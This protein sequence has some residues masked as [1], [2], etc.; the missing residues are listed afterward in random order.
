MLPDSPRCQI[1]GKIPGQKRLFFR[2]NFRDKGEFFRGSFWDN[3]GQIYGLIS[4]LVARQGKGVFCSG[5]LSGFCPDKFRRFRC[6]FKWWVFLLLFHACSL[7]KIGFIGLT[8]RAE[9]VAKLAVNRR[10]IRRKSPQICPGFPVLPPTP[11]GSPRQ[12]KRRFIAVNSRKKSPWVVGFNPGKPTRRNPLPGRWPGAK[13]ADKTTDKTGTYP[14]GYGED[15]LIF[16]GGG[17][18]PPSLA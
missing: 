9:I 4:G 17:V 10:K 18:P 16:F 11:W 5:F 2:D 7:K 14:G 3:G 8:Y 12:I 6:R 1:V 15:I 13:S